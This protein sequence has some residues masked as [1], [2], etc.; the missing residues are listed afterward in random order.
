[1]ALRAL[2]KGNVDVGVLQEKKLTDR[3][4]VRRE[5]GTPSGK[6]RQRLGMRWY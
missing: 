5:R 3:I 4:H 2:K 1:M 6:Q